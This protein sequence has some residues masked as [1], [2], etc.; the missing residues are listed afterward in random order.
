MTGLP[1]GTF[2][3]GNP[4]GEQTGLKRATQYK[5]LRGADATPALVL[6]RFMVCA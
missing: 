3:P 5:G 1:D 4:V 6:A 2:D